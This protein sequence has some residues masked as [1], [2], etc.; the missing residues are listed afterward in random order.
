MLNS[1]YKIAD[2]IALS[3][4]SAL[5]VIGSM[6]SVEAP[7]VDKQPEINSIEDCDCKQEYVSDLEDCLKELK[8]LEKT[9]RMGDFNG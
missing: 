4:I 6:G 7:K 9:I 5:I 8:S 2:M 1:I 3:A